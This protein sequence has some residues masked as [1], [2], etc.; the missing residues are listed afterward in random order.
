MTLDEALDLMYRGRANVVKLATAAGL[1]KAE[2][3]QV[4]GDYLSSRGFDADAWQ[5]NDEVSW[6]YIT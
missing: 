2:L 3:Q 6:P 1:S 5:K 4:F